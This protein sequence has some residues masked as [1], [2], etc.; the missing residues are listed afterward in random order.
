[1]RPQTFRD[2][3]RVG[4]R[5]ALSLITMRK[6]SYITKTVS[7]SVLGLALMAAPMAFLVSPSNDGAA[8]VLDQNASI[9]EAADASCKG[10]CG[11]APVS[12]TSMGRFLETEIAARIERIS[13]RTYKKQER[14]ERVRQIA[15]AVA[16]ASYTYDV[17]PFLLMAMIEVESRYNHMAHGNHGEIGLM[18]VKPSTAAWITP[19]TDAL[20]GC[21]L[22]GIR[23]NIMTGG[24]YVGHI[25]H[26]TEKRAGEI[27]SDL[28]TATLLR[29]HVL[30]SYNLGPAKANRL[31]QEYAQN[32]LD[33]AGRTPATEIATAGPIPYATKI[34][35]RADR[36]RSRYISAMTTPVR[37][38]DRKPK[39]IDASL[40]AVAMVQ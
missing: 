18:Q 30:R 8:Q 27:E 22:H 6:S 2:V 33:D 35:N 23:C 26:R 21:D 31:A 32:D 7:D 36:L 13:G 3:D 25:Q 12:K 11:E 1:M 4:R 39:S 19:V 29:E 24:R 14:L 28:T 16:E 38:L 20:Y 15:S 17:D 34:G 40:S 10:L 5:L 9:Q 37:S